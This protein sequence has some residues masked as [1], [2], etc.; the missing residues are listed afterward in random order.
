MKN[1]KWA[2]FLA[3]TAIYIVWG[4]T[5][6][7]I[8][9]AVKDFPPFLMT[10]LR[11]LLAGSLLFTWCLWR[12]EPMPS[13]LSVGKNAIY[14]ILM[15]FG[16]I[17]SVS[18]AEQYLPSS[19]A[20]IIVTAVP[21]WFILLDKKQWSLYFSNK[22]IIAGLLLGFA[23]VIILVS[24]QHVSQVKSVTTREQI[25]GSLFILA[26]GISW[27][28]GSLYS[29]YRPAGSSLLMNGSIQ[30]LATG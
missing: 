29:K 9:V 28:I 4:S 27:T 21:F 12:K 2:V 11:F 17:G 8:F 25:M 14:G 19:L 6:L 18:W 26:G 20:A 30:L 24:F 13:A 15:L 7:A 5:Y 22:M 16:G 10:A 3:F 23:G 1:N